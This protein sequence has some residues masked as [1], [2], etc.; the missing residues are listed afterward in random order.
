M[1]FSKNKYG[2]SPHSQCALKNG[3]ADTKN[4]LEVLT[5]KNEHHTTLRTILADRPDTLPCFVRLTLPALA[6]LLPF[7]KQGW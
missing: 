3:I 2:S 5:P 1:N 4:K 6:F 7:L